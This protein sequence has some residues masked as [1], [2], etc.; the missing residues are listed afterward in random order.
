MLSR[1]KISW[2]HVLCVALVVSTVG[3]VWFT[4]PSLGLNPRELHARVIA[5]DPILTFVLMALLPIFGFSIAIVYVIAGA[6]FGSGLGLVLI[7]FATAIHLIG[8]YWIARSFLRTRIEAL[9]SKRKYH[10]PTLPEEEGASVALLAALVPGLPY[11]AR[12]YLLGIAG[13]PLRTC[14]LVCLPVY[15]LRSCIVVLFGE[16][17]GNLT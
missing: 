14:L 2:K 11:A 10:L 4:L 13:I 3:L 8:S 7:T 5:L 6:R 1:T 16:F 17:S 15:V 9:L 12:N